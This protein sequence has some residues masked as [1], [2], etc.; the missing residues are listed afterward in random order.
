MTQTY[1][2]PWRRAVTG[3]AV[4]LT[5]LLL[6]QTALA[7]DGIVVSA[8]ASLKPAFTVMVRQF[9][10]DYPAVAV[11]TN[12]ASSPQLAS[13]IAQGA[14]VDVFA[15]ADRKTMDQLVGTGHVK[16]AAAFARSRLTVI[17]ANAAK[18][19]NPSLESLALPNMRLVMPSPK[20]PAAA[21]IAE[22]VKKADAAGLAGGQFGARLQANTVSQ[23]PDARMVVTKVALGEADAAIV[24]ATD[25]TADVR[26]K[27]TEV[28]IPPALN[29]Q[30]EYVIGLV[31]RSTQAADALKF[32]EY[33]RSARGQAVLRTF[34]F[35]TE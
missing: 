1:S 18:P 33:V 22:F 16:D 32:F 5:H 21:Y 9:Q 17:F 11:R 19:Q 10:S 8:A 23:E 34:G 28:P 14:Q 13:Q 26:S 30:A 31:Q 24:Y 7:G 25:L 2:P 27:V 35:S 3:L 6:P 4:L 15:S 20:I 12:F 29:V